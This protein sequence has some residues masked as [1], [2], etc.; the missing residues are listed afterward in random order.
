MEKIAYSIGFHGKADE[1][2]EHPKPGD[3]F[4]L[5]EFDIQHLSR[6]CYSLVNDVERLEAEVADLRS[7]LAALRGKRRHLKLRRSKGR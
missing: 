7:E 2:P 4:G 6:C 3:R 5:I 1:W